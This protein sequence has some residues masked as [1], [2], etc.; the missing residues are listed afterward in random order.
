MSARARFYAVVGETAKA[1]EILAQLNTLAN[2]R[3]VPAYLIARI[4]LGLGDIDTM[5]DLLEKAYD[6]RYGYLAYL[7]VE[8]I[9][10][11]VRSD[12][13]YEQLIRR[14]GLR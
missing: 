2:S 5:F 8:P 10:D 12:P 4:Y 14:V 7:E 9:F 13:R 6:E 11:S 3:Y 1:K